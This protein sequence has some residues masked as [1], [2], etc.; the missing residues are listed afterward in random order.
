MDKKNNDEK[1]PV[2]KPPMS[3]LDAVK[4]GTGKKQEDLPPTN[5]DIMIQVREINEETGEETVLLSEAINA[6]MEDN[7]EIP[8]ETNNDSKLEI[9]LEIIW[10]NPNDSAL[11]KYALAETFERI[12][13]ISIIDDGTTKYI[14][15]STND[16]KLDNW[17]QKAKNLEKSLFEFIKKT[18]LEEKITPATPLQL[19]RKILASII[20]KESL[21]NSL[22]STEEDILSEWLSRQ[23]KKEDDNLIG[24]PKIYFDHFNKTG[25]MPKVVA[26][27]EK[28]VW[29]IPDE[30]ELEMLKNEDPNETHIPLE[31]IEDSKSNNKSK[32]KVLDLN[33]F[34]SDMN[35][36]LEHMNKNEKGKTA[37]KPLSKSAARKLKKKKKNAN[38][39]PTI[40]GST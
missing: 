22:L 35:K 33:A 15:I 10:L 8:S 39:T 13:L 27:D 28:G 16:S 17:K 31:F 36:I 25:T 11:R 5:D 2:T 34:K 4:K 30:K 40:N 24:I 18:N 3:F 14:D 9:D 19:E 12:Y 26:F 29:F 32:N 38:K 1:K 37:S 23:K 6:F 21:A 7:E 20:G